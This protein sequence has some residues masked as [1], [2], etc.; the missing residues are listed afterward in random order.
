MWACD[1]IEAL[2]AVEEY[3]GCCVV[4]KISQ[5]NY[6]TIINIYVTDN[7]CFSYNYETKKLTKISDYA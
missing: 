4:S 6:S 1:V 2:K 7:C 5:P 3:C